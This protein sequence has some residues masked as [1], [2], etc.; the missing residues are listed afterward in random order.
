[1]FIFRIIFRDNVFIYKIISKNNVCQ[2][3]NRIEILFYNISYFIS[4]FYLYHHTQF[5]CLS[6]FV[7]KNWQHSYQQ[8]YNKVSN[9]LTR[10]NKHPTIFERVRIRLFSVW[11]FQ[12]QVVSD[13]KCKRFW[14]RIILNLNCFRFMLFHGFKLCWIRF[15]SNSEISY[16]N[17]FDPS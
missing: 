10:I 13:S 14:V 16:S 6:F 3:P 2:F 9:I 4:P 11:L 5:L 1:M 7:N 15:I 12:V 17:Q 8:R